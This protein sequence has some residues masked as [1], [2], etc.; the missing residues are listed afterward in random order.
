MS[1][2][3]E[4]LG[5]GWS[6]PPSFDINTQ[7]VW[8]V[9]A[10]DDIEQSLRIIITTRVGERIMQPSFGASM[11]DV[12]FESITLSLASLVEDRIKTAIF[13]FEPRVDLNNVLVS[14]DQQNEGVVLIEVDYTVVATNT[15][16]NIVFPYYL[17]EGT[18]I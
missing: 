13:Q 12:M 11:D 7:S 16:R 18:D 4:F 10:E 14:N 1:D 5:T 15:R 9:S 17:N 3:K 6:F 8:M 2:G